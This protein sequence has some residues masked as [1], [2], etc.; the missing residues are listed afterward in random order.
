MPAVFV[1]S[2][3]RDLPEYRDAQRQLVASAAD[4]VAVLGQVAAGAADEDG[5][6]GASL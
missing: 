2:T 1:S 4:G 5:G 6:H 3:S